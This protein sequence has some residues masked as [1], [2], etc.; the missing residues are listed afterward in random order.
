L[1]LKWAFSQLDETGEVMSVLPFLPHWTLT[2]EQAM[3]RVQTQD[4]AQ[5]FAHLVRRWQEPI[6]RLCTQMTDDPHRGDDLTQEVFT[7]VFVHRKSYRHKSRFSTF[8]WRIAINRCQNERRTVQRRRELS[9]SDETADGFSQVGQLA[10]DA[11]LPDARMVGQERDELVRQA[12]LRLSD[13][14]RTVVILRHY[15]D[16]K[17]REI[18]EILDIPEGTVK[19]RMAEALSQLARL[20]Q[21]IR[22]DDA[23]PAPAVS[24]NPRERTRHDPPHV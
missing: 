9:L 11:P 6:R 7:Q 8:L 17:F 1:P 16:L 15:E 13:C 12:L 10:D 23:R 2:D 22:D 24:A 4:D 3:R 18:A 20:L 19:S 21:P 14:Y 5:A